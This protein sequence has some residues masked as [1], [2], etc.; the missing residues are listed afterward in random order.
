MIRALAATALAIGLGACAMAEPDYTGTVS[1]SRVVQPIETSS[2]REQAISIDA[3]MASLPKEAGAIEQVTYQSFSDGMRQSMIFGAAIAGLP[4]NRI[5]LRLRTPMR[6]APGTGAVIQLVKPTEAAIRAELTAEFPG[7]EMRVVDPPRSNAYGVYGLA[8]GRSAKGASCIYAWQWLDR[9]ETPD[10]GDVVTPASL[11]L[12]LCALGAT[13]D[14]LARLFDQIR[15]QP[16]RRPGDPQID[17]VATVRAPKPAGGRAADHQ[18]QQVASTS[19]S[20]FNAAGR[21]SQWS[22]TSIPRMPAATVP[23]DTT[24]PAAA[25]RGP[26]NVAARSNG[27]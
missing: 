4:P 11:R 5:D 13:P 8:T 16:S 24:L 17:G 12:R 3:R 27:L 23:L 7:M 15:L 25:F 26:L 2:P 19:A 20:R 21:P 10:A 1:Q 22:M 18:R 6:S 9:L 14:Q